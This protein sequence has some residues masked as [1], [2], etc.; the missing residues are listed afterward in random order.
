[1][2]TPTTPVESMEQALVAPPAIIDEPPVE[3]QGTPTEAP[4]DQTVEGEQPEAGPQPEGEETT[5]ETTTEAETAAA[6]EEP[7]EQPIG[8]DDLLPARKSKTYPDELFQ[9]AARKWGFDPE[10]LSDP[11]LGPHLKSLLTDKIN[12]D[13]EIAN[14]RR[15][16][17]LREREAPK[18][19][20]KPAEKPKEEAKEAPPVLSYK[21]IDNMAGAIA[22]QMVTDEGAES[23]GKNTYE[24]YGKILAIQQNDELSDEQKAVQ[25]KGA[26]RDLTENFTRFGVMLL[27]E[28]LPQTFT[29]MLQGQQSKEVIENYLKSAQQS[30]EETRSAEEQLYHDAWDLVK[31]EPGYRDADQFGGDEGLAAQAA[32]EYE[33]R[34]GID[35]ETIQ[36]RDPESGRVLSGVER[37]TAMIKFCIDMARAKAPRQLPEDVVKRAIETGRKEERRQSTTANL[38][39]LR[40]GKASGQFERTSV[41]DEE[42]GDMIDAYRAPFD[43]VNR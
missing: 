41:A 2:P 27:T 14:H 31:Q 38:G 39:R 21:E 13:I 7:E 8:Y 1:M 35:P 18:E 4:G 16:Q 28:I 15:D 23:F 22:K 30:H 5:E 3:D 25:L 26:Y 20:A 43:T 32:N 19:E 10:D 12:S 34:T 40:T 17:M 42:M 33:D 9:V 24:G 11:R 29:S 36:F 37:A 6:A